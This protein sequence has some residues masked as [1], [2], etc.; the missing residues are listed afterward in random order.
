MSHSTEDNCIIRALDANIPALRFVSYILLANHVRSLT[1]VLASV[2]THNH[3][4]HWPP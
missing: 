4:T 3:T 1:L 2:R